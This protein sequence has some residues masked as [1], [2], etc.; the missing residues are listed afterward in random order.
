MLD[1]AVG[2]GCQMLDLAVGISCQILLADFAV[3]YWIWL[4]DFRRTGPFFEDLT[5][6]SAISI[7]IGW[8]WR[9]SRGEK[10]TVS[11]H[12][13]V[14][15]GHAYPRTYESGTSWK[16]SGGLDWASLLVELLTDISFEKYVEANI[17]KPLGVVTFTWHLPRK[18]HVAEKLTRMTTRK[19][20]GTLSDGLNPFSPELMKEAGGLGMYSDV[21]DYTRVLADLLKDSPVLLRKS[22]VDKMFTP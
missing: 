8:A 2:F 20:D 10:P 19:D 17:A 22:L 6:K 14:A 3:S 7:G 18:L 9:A 16:Y 12:G 13:D 1:L 15:K 21:H 4:L 5:A 11:F